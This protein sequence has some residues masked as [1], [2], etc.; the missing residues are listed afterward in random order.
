MIFRVNYELFLYIR[1]NA[2]ETFYEGIKY[3]KV[4]SIREAV[5][6]FICYLIELHR[7]EK[8]I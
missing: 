4:N 1:S 3:E 7:I 8:L 2:E 6:S 5:T